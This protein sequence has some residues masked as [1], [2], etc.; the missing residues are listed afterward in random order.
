MNICIALNNLTEGMMVK[1]GI[2]KSLS[3]E[4][5]SDKVGDWLDRIVS[6][7]N[8]LTNLIHEILKSKDK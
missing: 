4:E 7:R 2:D 6:Q 3:E 1:L 8:E 5:L